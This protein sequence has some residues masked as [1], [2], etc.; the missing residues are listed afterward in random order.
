MLKYFRLKYLS[1]NQVNQINLVHVALLTHSMQSDSL[2]QLQQQFHSLDLEK[3]PD[4][5]HPLNSPLSAPSNKPSYPSITSVLLHSLHPSPLWPFFPHF[6]LSFAP[7][8]SFP[9]PHKIY[10]WIKN[11]Y[12]AR[13]KKLMYLVKSIS[14]W[15]QWL[16]WNWKWR[17]ESERVELISHWMFENGHFLP[18]IPSLWN[19]FSV[20]LRWE[21]SAGRSWLTPWCFSECALQPH[22]VVLFSSGELH[23]SKP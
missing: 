20:H 5:G 6:S 15:I 11:L 23:I 22:F 14:L 7:R 18:S 9:E 4:K 3:S 21:R 1:I 16:K 8:L 13:I 19:I 17:Q 10:I 2:C 12:L